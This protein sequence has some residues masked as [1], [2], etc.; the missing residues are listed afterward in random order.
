VLGVSAQASPAEL[1]RAFRRRM[2]E[3]HPDTGGS[4]VEFDRVLRAWELVGTPEA[5]AAY[6]SGTRQ[7]GDGEGGRTWAPPAPRKRENASRPQARTHG[8]P[9][10]W[11]R[12]R[13]LELLREW[14]GRGADIPDPYDPALVRSAP[15]EVRH[16]LAAAIAEEQSAVALAS[17]GL[18]FTVWHDV[19]TPAGKV[20]HIVLGP[21]GLWGL[22]SEDFGGEVK[23]R[24]GD[25]VGGDLHPDDRPMHEL[26]RRARAVE[27]SARVRF[28]ALAVVV[29]DGASAEG[30]AQLGSIRGARTLLVQRPRLAHLIRTGIPGVGV[31]GTDLFE[32]RTRV[33]G[34]VR[35]V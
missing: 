9:G 21:T 22:L 10:G 12:E 24:R 16:L 11:Y 1:R 15:G 2:R 6:D 17:L 26:A 25:L 28:S 5:R 33:Q 32:V 30:V 14:V 18:G 27:K 19:D 8:H 35:F 29:P 23:V 3:T 34:A 13:Y 20:D 7:S 4:A 31:G